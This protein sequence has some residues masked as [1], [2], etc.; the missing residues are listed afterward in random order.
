MIFFTADVA[1][2]RE[3]ERLLLSGSRIA[4]EEVRAFVD[5]GTLIAEAEIVRRTPTNKRTT[6]GR[7]RGAIN[8]DVQETAGAI[9]GIV[10]VANVPYAP[11]VEEDTR[12]HIIQARN[13]RALAFS[14]VVAFKV[15]N[16]GGQVLRGRAVYRTAS[17]GTTTNQ[18]KAKVVL[19]KRVRHPGTKGQHMFR[20]GSKAATP[21]IER[22][23][24][25]AL[26]R[27][28]RRLTG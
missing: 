27:I 9:R 18:A 14:P 11:F 23:A 7:L 3:L 21:R 8:S 24:A 4:R 16:R 13:A 1:G 26:A 28:A 6:G 17:G 25:Q 10:G 22:E 20:D 19:R 5:R 15:V 2:L 12:P